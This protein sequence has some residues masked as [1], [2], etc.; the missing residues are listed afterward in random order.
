MALHKT[1]SIEFIGYN[2]IEVSRA[3]LLHNLQLFKQHTNQQVIPVLKG[4]AYGH[5]IT[6]VTE[7]LQGQAMPY[8]AVNDYLEAVRIREVSPTPILIMGAIPPANFAR[9][10]YSNFAFVV[11]DSA[12]V[13]ALGRTGKP[14][15]IHVECNTGMNRYGVEQNNLSDFTKLILSYKNLELEGIMSHLA[16]SDGD[17][18]ATVIAAVTRFD[19]CVEVMRSAG[20]NPRIIHIAQTAGSV[21]AASKYANTVR[22]GI[23]LYGIN[24]FP[25]NHPHYARLKAL[26]PALTF[27][28]T[29]TQINH[30]QK[31]D[32]VSYNY[33]FTAP[34]PMDVGV[35]P[36][37]Y[38]EGINRT[39]SNKGVVGVGD[40]YSRIVGYI[41]MNHTM[42]S[43]ED[44]NAKI[45][46]EVVIYSNDP[47][48]KNSINSIAAEHQL[49]AYNLLTA[50]N[51]DIQRV[52][53]D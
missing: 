50:L 27:I 47:Q 16:D 5:G 38:Y 25:Q 26:Q 12:T 1:N 13:A 6:L 9:L 24:P 33:T 23:G 8:I 11:R 52:L 30:L 10:N 37:G 44:V 35:L 14:I 46:D 28:S 29:L 20:A 42:I 19:R 41:C 18:P 3:A 32:Q 21:R 53:V 34:K 51:P 7:A 40:S 49:F 2:R 45:G 17:N 15:K 48:A 43:L 22:V 4:N 36:V 31:G 39:L